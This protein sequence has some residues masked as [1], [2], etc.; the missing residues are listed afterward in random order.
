LE[1]KEEGKVVE[2]EADAREIVDVG[3]DKY[4]FFD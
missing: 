1:V 4:F 3:L 2:G